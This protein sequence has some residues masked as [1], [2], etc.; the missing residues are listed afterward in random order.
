MIRPL[1][2]AL[3]AL[4]LAGGVARAQL[5]AE[6]PGRVLALPE[7]PGAHWFWLSDIILHRTALFDGD[8]GSQLAAISSGS[9][10]VGFVISPLFARDRREIYLAETY[11]SRGVRGERTDVVT[12]YDGRTLEAVAE[13]PIP[14]RRAEYFPGNAANALSDDGRFV[15]VFNLTPVTSLSIVDVRE[16]RF[17]TEVS[18][19]GCSLVYA[20][21]P[22]RFLM[23]CANGTA[24]IVGL[25][26]DGGNPRAERT[27]V[28]FDPQ[29]DPITEK[30]VR[31]GDEWLFVSFDGY[32]HPV[33]VGGD[34]PGFGERW[35]L[36]DDADRKASWR[37]GG[38]QHLAIHAGSKRLYALMHQGP[39]D[40]HKEPG[41]EVWV[42]DLAGRRRVQR[43]AVANPVASFVRQQIAQAGRER[44]GRLTG[45]L[46]E[47]LFG[48]PGVERILVT[49]DDHPVLVASASLP[50]TLTIHDAMTGA[51]LREISEPGL[52][53]SL[54]FA[55]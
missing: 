50:P 54:L 2:R 32:I 55:P 47:R 12:V 17:V 45:W 22:R 8:T 37:I 36:L 23:L 14:P 19:P 30:A 35:S 52:A 49:Q 20:A 10:G 31:H 15:A 1:F 28:F 40:T 33:G 42:Y 26:E 4:L 27:P 3:L 39:P 21:G 46:L 51:V 38:P 53:A 13:I 7:R 29:K 41:T 43:I 16:R 11:Y 5:E 48:N 44:T 18:T 9:A 34:R 6:Q 24:L 25:D